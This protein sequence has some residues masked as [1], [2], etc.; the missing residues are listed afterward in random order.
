ML[1]KIITG[2]PSIVNK[3]YPL[4]F[5]VVF[6]FVGQKLDITYKVRGFSDV[7]QS[8]ITF[9]S[10]IIGFYSAMYGVLIT[11]KDTDVM[12]QFRKEHLDGLF[13]WQLYESL[14]SSF[15]VLILATCLQV[16]RHYD[17]VLANLVFMA[18]TFI[19]GWFLAN[20]FRTV[21][22]LLQIMFNS[23]DLSEYGRSDENSNQEEMA[24]Q[25]NKNHE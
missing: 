20:S 14:G 25:I 3:I 7:L 19:L 1:K 22:L 5:G 8:V 16:F 24:N 10:I 2:V 18:F 21:T 4:I 9:S 13:K 11:L 15:S 12:V 6:W 17:G 23:S